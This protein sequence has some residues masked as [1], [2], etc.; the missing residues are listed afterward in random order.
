MAKNVELARRLGLLDIPA[1]ALVDVEHVDELRP[2]LGVRDVDRLT[3]RA[4]VRPVAHGGGGEQVAHLRPDD[5]VIISAHPI[6]G[7]EWAV[8]KVIDALHRRGAG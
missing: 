4:P 1:D 8:G 5:V 6:P 7:N 3:G 2:G